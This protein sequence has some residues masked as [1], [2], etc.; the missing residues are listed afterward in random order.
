[1][2][3]VAGSQEVAQSPA[4]IRPHRPARAAIVATYAILLFGGFLLFFSHH[5]TLP[6]DSYFSLLV[7]QSILTHHTV[8]L[9]NY[10]IPHGKPYSQL[11]FGANGYPYHITF[12]H[13]EMLYAFPYGSSVL[14]VPF[15]GVLNLVGISILKPDGSFSSEGDVLA[16]R[17][18]AGFL[19]ALVAC[20]FF[21][22]ALLL[23]PYW[24]SLIAALAGALG[25]QVWS[26]GSQVLWSFDWQL[27]LI[28]LALN[29]LLGAAVR[30]RDPNPWWLGSLLAWAYFVRPTSSISIV[31]ISAYVWLYHR[32][33]LIPYAAAGMLWLTGFVGFWYDVFGEPL[34][35]YFQPTRLSLSHFQTA[36][37]NNLVG[38]ARGLLIYMPVVGFV[39]YLAAR[40]WRNLRFR[41]IA[42]MAVCVCIAH[43]LCISMFTEMWWAGWCYGARFATD[44]VPW[45]MLLGVLGLDSMTRRAALR[46]A[47]RGGRA[48][49]LAAGAALLILS[50]A[51]QGHGAWS[52]ATDQWNMWATCHI[53]WRSE[54]PADLLVDWRY[55]Q[56]LA[57]LIE[58][59]SASP[60]VTAIRADDGRLWHVGPSPGQRPVLRPGEQV[61][62]EGRGFD[63]VH[64]V[65]LDV[66]CQ[67]PHGRQGPFRIGAPQVTRFQAKFKLPVSIGNGAGALQVTNPPCAGAPGEKSN[68][69]AV[70]FNAAGH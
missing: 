33:I 49:E 17:I 55:P 26:T 11:A 41:P 70:S 45:L 39:I 37:A 57:G 19:M 4:F 31:A 3:A 52:R 10:S 22:T 32:R 30:R 47:T 35:D 34:P 66:F 24:L 68:A 43:L 46:Q 67:C 53:P 48:V 16:E 25:T 51:I 64:G 63:Q 28:A 36:L 65:A 58:P 56:F 18:I 69:V 20:I 14:S 13:G 60:V 23:L 29:A 38:P 50:V 54:T 5:A 2:S 59:P 42:T 62:I 9:N 61:V 12:R 15:V 8:V 44:L 7:S 40:Y 27:V 1:M 6:S 21:A